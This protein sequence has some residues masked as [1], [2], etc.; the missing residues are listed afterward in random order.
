VRVAG[1]STRMR[2]GVEVNMKSVLRNR[3]KG[4]V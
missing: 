4:D 2:V 1:D 3:I